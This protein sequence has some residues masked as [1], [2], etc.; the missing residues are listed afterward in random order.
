MPNSLKD[1]IQLR[2]ATFCIK[3]GA[4]MKL[5]ITE[6]DNLMPRLVYTGCCKNC[7]WEIKQP[8]CNQSA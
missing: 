2:L 7:G 6:R 4:E 5:E 3:C 1:A 8:I